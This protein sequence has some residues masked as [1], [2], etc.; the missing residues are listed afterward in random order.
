M[1]AY[2]KYI[3]IIEDLTLLLTDLKVSGILFHRN[4]AWILK[5]Y[6]TL[7]NLGFI[8]FQEVN[9]ALCCKEVKA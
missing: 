3:N 7:E 6:E 9:K 5:I 2:V 4:F 8:A 1:T